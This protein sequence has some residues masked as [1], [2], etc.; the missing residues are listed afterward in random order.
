MV[1]LLAGSLLRAQGANDPFTGT[2]TMNIAKSTYPQGTCPK[3]MVIT[4]EAVR[5]GVH[6]HSITVQANGA[7]SIADYT[8]GY[9]GRETLVQGAAGFLLPVSLKRPAADTVIASYQR[10]MQVVATSRR[11][12]S[13]DGKSM[14]ITTVLTG[15]DG[16]AVTSIGVYD[17]SADSR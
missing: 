10:G 14:T 16:H 6:Y 2:W 11:E 17:R 7:S 13:R 8:A 4:M 12:V 15:K 5:G 9:D 3:S 1:V